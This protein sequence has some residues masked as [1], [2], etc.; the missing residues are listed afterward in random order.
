MGILIYQIDIRHGILQNVVQVGSN[1][2]ASR[3]L[4]KYAVHRPW[5]AAY[6]R[7]ARRARTSHSVSTSFA[8]IRGNIGIKKRACTCSKAIARRSYARSSANSHAPY[9]RLPTRRRLLYYPLGYIVRLYSV[10]ESADAGRVSSGQSRNCVYIKKKQHDT[11]S[12]CTDRTE[13]VCSSF[14]CPPARPDGDGSNGTFN[15]NVSKAD[16]PPPSGRRHVPLDR[17]GRV[18][19]SRNAR[20]T[21]IGSTRATL[22]E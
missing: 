8:A 22:F 7:N 14:W 20:D 13:D 4:P 10:H 21:Q 1:L 2:T 6:T 9:S 3:W 18:S 17:S 12:E 5:K 11:R 15:G 16:G 19:Q